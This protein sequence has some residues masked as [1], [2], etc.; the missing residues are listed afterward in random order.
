MTDPATI[1]IDPPDIFDGR[2]WQDWSPQELMITIDELS[3]LIRAAVREERERLLMKESD[4]MRCLGYLW[5]RGG[6]SRIHL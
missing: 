2:A 3:K 5:K 1:Q 6:R 4:A